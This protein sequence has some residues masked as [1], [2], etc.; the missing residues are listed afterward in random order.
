M[1]RF[2]KK[3]KNGP[4]RSAVAPPPLSRAARVRTEYDTGRH[5]SVLSCVLSCLAVLEPAR[6]C[7]CF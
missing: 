4:F 3:K 5:K 7:R 1:V 2:L 6:A